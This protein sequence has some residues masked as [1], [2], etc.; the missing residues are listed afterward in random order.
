MN[1][2]IFNNLFS[3]GNKTSTASGGKKGVVYKVPK[4]GTSS[5]KP[6]IGKTKKGD[7]K[8]RG[9]ADDGRD[10]NKAEVIDEYNADD[11]VEGSYKEQKAINENGGIDNLDNK[12]NE[13]S[14]ERFNDAKKK[15]GK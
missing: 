8:K 11:A 5:G 2:S 7:P 13:M 3:K 12:R 15:Y 1:Q 4:E 9:G 6:Y 14:T 10:R